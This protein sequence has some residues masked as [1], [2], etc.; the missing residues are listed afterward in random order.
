VYLHRRQAGLQ[1]N[2]RAASIR[3][4]AAAHRFETPCSCRAI[5]GYRAE[6]RQAPT[7][8]VAVF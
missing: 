7:T 2:L 1:V 3:A 8:H 6:R 5:R 4:V